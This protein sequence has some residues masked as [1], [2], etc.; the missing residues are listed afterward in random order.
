MRLYQLRGSP[1]PG[2]AQAARRTPGRPGRACA[3]EL[4]ALYPAVEIDYARQALAPWSADT[5]T[6]R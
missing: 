5:T 2:Y 6:G 1:A 4:D 3:W